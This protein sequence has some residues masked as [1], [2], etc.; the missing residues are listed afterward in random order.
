M[1]LVPGHRAL[2]EQR[3]T[4]VLSPLVLLPIT[5]FKHVGLTVKAANTG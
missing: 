2:K 1:G 5:L 3:G 4:V